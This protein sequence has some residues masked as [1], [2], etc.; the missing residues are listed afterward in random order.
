MKSE[1]VK[2]RNA[3]HTALK[4]LARENLLTKGVCGL[5]PRSNIWRWKHEPSDK[6]K[7]FDLNL[8]GTQDY[9][10]IRSFVQNKNAKQIFAAYVRLSKFFV[11]LVHSVPK[12]HKHVN[13]KKLQVVR[14]IERVKDSLG[15]KNVLRVFNI[16]V[17][18][19]RQWKLDTVTPCFESIVNRCNRIYPTQLSKSEVKTMK[20]KLTD[21]LHQ[22]WPISSI[23]F[24]SLRNGSLPLSLNTWYKYANRMGVNRPKPAD[25]RKKFLTGILANRP[26]RIWHADITRFVTLDNVIHYIYLVVDNFRGKYFRGALPTKS[27][28]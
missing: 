21:P 15:L 26:N 8:R 5:I 3:Y 11:D 18:T 17:P 2:N 12:F 22:Y 4:C 24:H 19:F 20:E 7:T 1:L 9:E 25:R 27:V 13:K 10:L 6:Y 14:I 28:L 23:A 16:S